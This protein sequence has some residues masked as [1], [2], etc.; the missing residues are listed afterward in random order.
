MDE[1]L[2]SLDDARKAEILPYIER[3]R[4]E[5][6]TP[7]VYVSH[8]VAEVA[9]LATDVV[10]LADGRVAAHGRT[11]EVLQQ[12]GHL[13]PAERGE[14]GA[15]LATSVEAH[16]DFY[17][18]TV[19]RSAAGELRVPRLAAAIGSKVRLHV[20]A[21]DVIVATERPHGLSA[22]NVLSGT[23]SAIGSRASPL[24]EIRIDCGGEAILSRITRR[25][26][27]ALGLEPGKAVFAIV[28]SVAFDQDGGPTGASLQGE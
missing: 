19:L 27:D 1:P 25:S 15:V 13:P 8:S 17:A 6:R 5:S 23:V 22:L 20:R 18:M 7:I 26:L 16:D 21:R 14:A 11:S 4:D 28:K 24:V 3:L 10:V 12:P 9:R 2:A